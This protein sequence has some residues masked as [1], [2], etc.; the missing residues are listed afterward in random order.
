MKSARVLH[1]FVVILLQRRARHKERER[2]DFFKLEILL[3]LVQLAF[4]FLSVLF[5][6]YIGIYICCTF[7]YD[8]FV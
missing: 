2:G 4:V 3:T 8:L 6:T 1:T 7:V 5:L